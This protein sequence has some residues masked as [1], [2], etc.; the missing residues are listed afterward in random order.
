MIKKQIVSVLLALAI[1]LIAQSGFA[2]CGGDYEH[3]RYNP[4]FYNG[5]HVQALTS[6]RLDYK[7][8]CRAS[9]VCDGD[10]GMCAWSLGQPKTTM[11]CS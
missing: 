2:N 1:T 10:R 6:S 5:H 7:A 4:A 11:E 8:D 3:I 9:C